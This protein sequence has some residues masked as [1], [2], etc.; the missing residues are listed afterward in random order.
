[1]LGNWQMRRA[2]EKMAL[3]QRVAAALS[4]PAQVLDARPVDA[5]SL[6]WHQLRMHGRWLRE[7]AIYLDNRP[8]EGRPGLYVLMPLQLADG[9]VVLC[10]RGWLAH[11]VR[12]R[13]L[14][15]NYETPSGQ[16]EVEGVAIPDEQRFLELGKKAPGQLGAIWQNFDFAQYQQV[17]GFTLAPM[18]VRVDGGPDDGLIRSWPDRGAPFEAR[19]ARN[20][21]YAVQW[22]AMACA[23]LAFYGI[24]HVRKRYS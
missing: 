17:S 11:D 16:I 15:G 12:Q 6:V 8:F 1:M 21:G 2:D 14:I 22:Y 18:I 10:N 23:L 3:Q 24:R 13:A 9:T 19:I 5:A 4:A 7:D 20:H